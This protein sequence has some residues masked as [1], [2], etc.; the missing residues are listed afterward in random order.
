MVENLNFGTSGAHLRTWC[1]SSWNF[2]W[3]SYYFEN[4]YSGKDLYICVKFYPLSP[5]A[6]S[7]QLSALPRTPAC[8]WCT[9]TPYYVYG[10]LNSLLLLQEHLMNTKIFHKIFFFSRIFDNSIAFNKQKYV[11][12]DTQCPPTLMVPFKWNLIKRQ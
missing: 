2:R 11:G 4:V 12:C 1:Q 9:C 3:I 5:N 8:T 7:Y 6:A 10:V